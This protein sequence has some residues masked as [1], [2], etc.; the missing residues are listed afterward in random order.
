MYS[1]AWNT[2]SRVLLLR[3]DSEGLI[4]GDRFLTNRDGQTLF[5]VLSTDRVSL[6]LQPRLKPRLKFPGNTPQPRPDHAPVISPTPRQGSAPHAAVAATAGRGRAAPGEPCRRGWGSSRSRSLFSAAAGLFFKKNFFF[7]FF[8]FFFSFFFSNP[9][10]RSLR[11]T[12]GGVKPQPPSERK[13]RALR[14]T[15][16]AAAVYPAPGSPAARAPPPRSA[17]AR[18]PGVLGRPRGSAAREPC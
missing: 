7:F 16:A 8:H 14:R 1:S 6:A 15:R 9:R 3:G 2:S 4:C 18:W 5:S 11:G 10:S 12:G 13:Q 17:P